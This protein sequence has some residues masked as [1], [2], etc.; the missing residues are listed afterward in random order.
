MMRGISS[1]HSTSYIENVFCITK[2]RSPAARMLANGPQDPAHGTPRRHP[3][4]RVPPHGRHRVAES[5]H[6]SAASAAVP[7]KARRSPASPRSRQAV[8]TVSPM[9]RCLRSST[10]ASSSADVVDHLAPDLAVGWPLAD[11]AHAVQRAPADAEIGRGLP[12]VEIARTGLA[13]CRA[14][15]QSLPRRSEPPRAARNVRD[16]PPPRAIPSGPGAA[17]RC[18]AP[19]FASYV[20]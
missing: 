18:P 3:S 13:H 15:R 2:S 7:A 8:T 12:G 11:L 5:R 19:P 1:L 4:R 9:K 20:D 16:E 10:Q 6:S 17:T 14:P